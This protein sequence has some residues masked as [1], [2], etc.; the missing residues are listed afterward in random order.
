MST[1]V[2]SNLATEPCVSGELKRPASIN[3]EDG[4]FLDMRLRFLE[5]CQD[6]LYKLE[7]F[8][9]NTPSNRLTAVYK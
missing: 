1:E 6:E 2:Y 4:T 9:P 5:Q 3:T 8:Q 7:F